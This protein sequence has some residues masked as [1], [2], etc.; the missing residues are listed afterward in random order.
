MIRIVMWI[1]LLAVVAM[2]IMREFELQKWLVSLILLFTGTFLYLLSNFLIRYYIK[3]HAPEFATDQEI[4]P[5][6]QA[7]EATAG[8]G[9]VPKWATNIGLVGIAALF[10]AIVPWL[11]ALFL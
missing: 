10:T 7:W 5:N 4:S 9:V 3:K 1:F 8:T 6:Q 2:N 11:I